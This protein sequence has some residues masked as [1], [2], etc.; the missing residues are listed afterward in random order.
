MR[1]YDVAVVGL[2]GMGSAAAAALAA[3]RKRVLG[4][5]RFGPARDRG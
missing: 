3:R 4:L 5:E 2:G 1:S